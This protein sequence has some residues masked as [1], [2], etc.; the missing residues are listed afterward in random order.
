MGVLRTVTALEHEFIPIVSDGGTM[1]PDPLEATR[2]WLLPSEAEQLM[3]LN[4]HRSSFC[5]RYHGGVKLAQYCGIVRLTTCVLEILPKLG[6]EDDF[7]PSEV[8]R[9]RA[10][11]LSMLHGARQLPMTTVGSAPQQIATGPLLDT[12]IEAFLDSALQQAREGLLS[13]Y[14]PHADDL[15]VL[16]GRLVS[17]GHVRRNYARPHLLYCEYDEFTTDNPYNQAVQAALLACRDGIVRTT[18]YRKWAEVRA[19]FASVTERHMTAA[20][21]ERL[22]QDRT[23]RRYGP[24]LRWCVWLLGLQSPSLRVG[25]AAAPGLLFDMNKLFEAYVVRRYEDE[26]MPSQIVLRQGPIRPLGAIDGNDVFRLK[27]D[28]TVWDT[29]PN[30]EPS[31]IVR[32]ADAKWKRVD[33]QASDW[34]IAQSDVY[35]LIA[36][37][38]RYGCQKLELV[39]P[40]LGD[41]PIESQSVHVDGSELG[42]GRLTITAR[43]MP[44]STEI[45]T[46]PAA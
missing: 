40:V 37:G 15:R 11:L 8:K 39:Y 23:T 6:E 29:A 4:D 41:V 33:R 14:V 46:A 1:A 38:L 10:A 31:T 17:Q 21:V 2:P 19:R 9:G 22:P 36:Y 27:P 35:Q 26:T 3:R 44:I 45:D 28:V 5:Q 43:L 7:T 18:T 13:R 16:K 32:I 30:G 34:G 12:F 25:A 20:D 42:A 24:L